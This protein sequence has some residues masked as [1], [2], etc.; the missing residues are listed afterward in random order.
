MEV[1]LAVTSV[2]SSAGQKNSQEDAN[3]ASSKEE[4]SS[5]KGSSQEASG[6]EAGGQEEDSQEEVKL[7]QVLTSG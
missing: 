1:P 3:Y 2:E 7:L 6:Q 5:E 4:G